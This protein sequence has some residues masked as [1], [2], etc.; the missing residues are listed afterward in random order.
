[1]S[2]QDCQYHMNI[3][4]YKGN[5]V[6]STTNDMYP[7][8]LP[9]VHGCMIGRVAYNNPFSLATVDST[10]YQQSDPCLTRREVIE[11]YL[12]YCDFIQV[13]SLLYDI[14]YCI[15]VRLF[16]S[17]ICTIYETKILKIK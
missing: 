12:T 6:N 17:N 14:C 2:L 16:L 5:D 15:F 11:R 7:E 1:M 3:E 13:R 4:G 9:P 10:F 8:Y